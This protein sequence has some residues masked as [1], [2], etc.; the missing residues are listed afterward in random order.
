M[1]GAATLILILAAG[2]VAGGEERLLPA[3]AAIRC[4]G[5]VVE[6]NLGVLQF[7]VP[8]GFKVRREVGQ[9][10]D[11]HYG[12]TKGRRARRYELLI[13][14]GPY[15]PG[16]LPEWAQKCDVRRWRSPDWKGEDCRL[17][18]VKSASRYI[19][20]NAPMGYAVY[21]DVPSEIA[22]RFDR[23]LDSLCWQAW[24]HSGKAR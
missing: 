19:T 6:D 1:L 18:G 3:C 14:S 21:E 22:A 4:D 20:L 17:A 5:R 24:R 11:V 12:I 10:G 23:I 15:F 13:T 16:R 9:H 8:R 2:Y 7:C